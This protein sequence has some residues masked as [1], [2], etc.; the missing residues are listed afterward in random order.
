MLGWQPCKHL[1]SDKLMSKIKSSESELFTRH[2]RAI[3]TYSYSRFK[4]FLEMSDLQR[5]PRNIYLLK[6]CGSLTWFFLD[7][8]SIVSYKQEMRKSL[9][10]MKINR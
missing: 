1:V 5:Y 9:L 2:L 10:Q 6:K 7:N 8:F 3:D 4:C